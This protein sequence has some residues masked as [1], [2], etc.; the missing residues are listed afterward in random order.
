LICDKIDRASVL[1]N[2]IADQT[3]E[4]KKIVKLRTISLLR[5]PREEKMKTPSSKHWFEFFCFTE[6]VYYMQRF[7]AQEVFSFEI[8]KIIINKL[9]PL[10]ILKIFIYL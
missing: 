4:K 10:S 9:I 3:K 6:K 2:F 1:S 7:G 5:F 8:S